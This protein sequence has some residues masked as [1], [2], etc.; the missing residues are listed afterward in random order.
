[1][2][3]EHVLLIGS[4]NVQYVRKEILHSRLFPLLSGF[5]N[6]I[7]FNYFVHNGHECIY[8]SHSLTFNYINKQATGAGS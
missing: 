3:S 6:A 7:Y 4:I 5:H 8:K 1:M 2:Y